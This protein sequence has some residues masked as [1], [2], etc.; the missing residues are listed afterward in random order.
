MKMTRW[1]IVETCYTPEKGLRWEG[2]LRRTDDA[3]GTIKTFFGSRAEAMDAIEKMTDAEALKGWILDDFH[4]WKDGPGHYVFE[5]KSGLREE[6]HP[7]THY[8]LSPAECG[9][10]ETAV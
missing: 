7:L 2:V 9:W 5:P 3:D 1:T 8:R 6:G 10:E 4:Y